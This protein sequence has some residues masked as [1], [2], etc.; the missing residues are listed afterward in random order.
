ML[1]AAHIEATKYR[2]LT[3]VQWIYRVD[4][5]LQQ[6]V[7]EFGPGCGWVLMDRYTTTTRAG[8][9][10]SALGGRP[11]RHRATRLCRHRRFRRVG[12]IALEK[13]ITERK[14]QLTLAVWWQIYFHC[15]IWSINF[16]FILLHYYGTEC[17]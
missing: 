11:R 15:L 17:K 10:R 4:H 7:S 13:E 3:I 5:Q 12:R 1:T 6:T 14:K 16:Q 9:P 8:R 2:R